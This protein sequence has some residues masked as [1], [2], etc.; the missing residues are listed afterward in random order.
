M[1]IE[2][3]KRIVDDEQVEQLTALLC[4]HWEVANQRLE[5]LVQELESGVDT[6]VESEIYAAL[7]RMQRAL[8]ALLELN[9]KPCAYLFS[10]YLD[11][12]SKTI[13]DAG[14][15]QSVLRL[16][17]LLSAESAKQQESFFD[18]VIKA[19]SRQSYAADE[20]RNAQQQAVSLQHIFGICAQHLT[21]DDLMM[22]ASIIQQMNAA[23]Q[24]V[25]PEE[26]V[27]VM[28]E[29][30]QTL[31]SLDK[32][33]SEN[34][35]LMVK[36]LVILMVLPGIM[37]SVMQQSRTD[38]RS[39]ARLFDKV[40][41][42]VRDSIEWWNY[43]RDYRETLQVV[44]DSNSMADIMKAEQ[45]KEREILGRVPG[46]L[47]AKWTG[48]KK[49]FN[50]EF[51]EA[52]LSD[53][54]LRHFLFHLAALYETVRE[55]DPTTKFGEERLVK[56]DAKRVGDAVMEAALKLNDLTSKA[57][58]PYYNK[59]WEELIANEQIFARLKVTR[60]SPHNNLFTARFF[61]HLVGGLKKR[62]VFG[63]HSDGDLAEKLTETKYVGTF[64]KNIQEGMDDESDEIKNIF[65][66][67]YLKYNDLI[68]S[69]K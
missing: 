60:N 13:S 42:R 54:E 17:E 57:W 36:W 7:M 1:T 16:L 50:A 35:Q 65:D 48:D 26:S 52:Q 6:C 24:S 41:L 3:I 8:T 49:V 2:E 66:T 29:M 67:I 21:P 11:R 34:R 15:R 64:R 27:D 59:V 44:Y 5:T 14:M 9:N 23:G 51:L 39:M 25:K 47:F 10:E 40:L 38:S 69:K 43:W 32:Q 28:N 53:D 56:D 68:H 62:A 58:F 33:M 46:N 37:V 12:F 30:R 19:L 31:D 18:L 4:R 22:L 61:C 45:R 63:G 20:Q 55:L